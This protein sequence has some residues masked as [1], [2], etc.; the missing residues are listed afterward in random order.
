MK[1][2]KYQLS[3]LIIIFGLITSC[4]ILEPENDNIYD[5]EDIRS[6][7][8]FAE[9]ILLA[10]Y[11]DLPTSHNNF[12]LSYASD[13]AVNNDPTSNIKTVISGGWTSNSNPFREWNSAYESIFHLNYFLEEMNDIEWYWENAKTDSIFGVKLKAEAYALRAWNYFHLLQAHAGKGTNGEMLGVPIVDKVLETAKP[14]DYE[15]PRS[16]FNEL[17][18]FIIE[19]CKKANDVL[20]ARWTNTND[21]DADIAIGNIMVNRIN[22]MASRFIKAK[23]LLYAA[24]P[25]FTDGTY[26]YQMA[27]EAA[28]EIM[29]LNGGLSSVNSAN[30]N[31]LDFY[32]NPVVSNYQRAHREVLW[33]SRRISGGQSWERNNYPP[34][35]YGNGLT[36]PTQDLVNAFPMADGTPVQ[37]GKINSANPYSDRDPR[38]GKYILHNGSQFIMGSDTVTINTTAGSQ[39]AVGSTNNFATKTGYYLK[40]FMNVENVNLDPTVNSGG[41]H[42]YTYVRYSDVLLMF[43]EAANEAVGPDGNIG[44]YTARG[45]I[46]ALRDRVGI[47][48][49]AYVNGLD[50]AGMAELIRNE[51]RIELC[52]EKQRFWDLRRWKLI[53]DMNKAVHG[54]QVSSD[55]STYSYFQVESR[56]FPAYQIYGPIPYDETLKYA[57]IQN[58]GW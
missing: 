28:A 12:N 17:V 34:S 22:G 23:T 7:P 37:A 53:D 10:A 33:Y 46:N 54:V 44:G 15:I 42:Y 2:L 32:S 8:A 16:S 51:R 13:D 18:E 48:S 26:T 31:L 39:N 4:E 3:A 52:F 36:N 38:L 1:I 41:I 19:D 27:A 55:G 20:P 35:L 47:T 49:Q 45:V 21:P 40:K 50:K 57:L 29:D 11:R 9:G 5:L 25:A 14:S 24:S 43:A 56:V 58:E 30:N 6:V